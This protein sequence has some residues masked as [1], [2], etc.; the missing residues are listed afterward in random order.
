MW[1]LLWLVVI[2]AVVLG[3]VLLAL[4]RGEG[5]R[6]EPP[7]DLIVD[8]PENRLLT[9]SDVE[10]L[11]LPVALRGYQMSAVD[12]VLDRLAA[13]IALRE[14][15]LTALR[16]KNAAAGEPRSGQAEK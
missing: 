15:E 10:T 14:A 2:V 13:E 9:A 4:G 5:L 1:W 6:E 8:L 3:V 11:R 16:A 7:D 12:N